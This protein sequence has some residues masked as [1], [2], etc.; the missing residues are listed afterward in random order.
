[1][2]QEHVI[3][4]SPG[5]A[6]D[7]PLRHAAD[8][9]AL[10]VGDDS[11]SRLYWALVDPGLAESADMSFHEYDGTG[12]F[13]SSFSCDPARTAENLATV[14]EILRDV[15]RAGITAEELQQAKSKIGSRVV[16]SA[17]RS[18]GRMQALGMSWT[19]LKQYRSV[20]TELEA[21]DA[22]TLESI[23]QVLDRYP[24]DRATTLA[25][26]PLSKL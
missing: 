21:F 6:A 8:T 24:V 12:S 10:A 25:L 5:P 18:R 16:R 14:Q 13:Y 20:D 23:R 7:D 19:Y 17:E 3:M 11:G 2:T 4:I 9:L 15:Q 1:V 22:V 26:G